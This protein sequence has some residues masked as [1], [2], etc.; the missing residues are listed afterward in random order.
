[1]LHL[2][3]IKQ[4]EM[5]FWMNQ[6]DSDRCQSRDLLRCVLC[7]ERREGD[8]ACGGGEVSVS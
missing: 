3:V 5:N 8:D 7:C 2:L 4:L 1:M 6:S